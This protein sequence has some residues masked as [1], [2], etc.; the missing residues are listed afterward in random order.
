[1]GGLISALDLGGRARV[2]VFF[3]PW[4]RAQASAW[5]YNVMASSQCIEDPLSSSLL[6]WFTFLS[7][8]PLGY[9]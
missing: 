1:M 2:G 8:V 5:T 6:L 7:I 3:F 9:W 4:T